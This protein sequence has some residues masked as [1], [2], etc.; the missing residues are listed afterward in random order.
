[1]DPIGWMGEIY[2]GFKE[3]LDLTIPIKVIILNGKEHEIKFSRLKADIPIFILRET[4]TDRTQDVIVLE[5]HKWKRRYNIIDVR[6]G[7][8]IY[9]YDLFRYDLRKHQSLNM[10]ALRRIEEIKDFIR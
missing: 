6:K 9:Q 1:M 3:S 2:E 8:Y 4:Q 7:D 5:P 10:R